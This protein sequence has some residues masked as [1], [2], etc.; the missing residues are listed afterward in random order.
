MFKM[1]RRVSHPDFGRQIL[2]QA[3]GKFDLI[4]HIV[5]AH[6]ERWDG[7]GY[8]YGLSGESI[9]LGARILAI[10]DSYDAMTSER[11][12]RKAMPSSLAREELQW[13]AG[14]QFDPRVVEAF[15][16]VVAEQER[17][18]ERMS[19]ALADHIVTTGSIFE[20]ALLRRKVPREKLTSIL[21]SA[22]LPSLSSYPTMPYPLHVF[23]AKAA[24][25]CHVSWNIRKAQ[26][27]RYRHPCHSAGT[28]CRATSALRYPR[29]RQCCT[30]LKA[31]RYRS[32]CK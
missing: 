11:P 30:R 4:S 19:T 15:L 1:S 12:Y 13:C 26:W 17:A 6:H 21:N 2:A 27:P 14:S 7:N 23:P 29:Q 28:S 8:P 5:V 22:D 31:T 9:P 25:H 16:R 24:I 32:G 18:E 20:E 10:V 3:G